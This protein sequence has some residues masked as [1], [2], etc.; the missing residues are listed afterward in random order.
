MIPKSLFSNSIKSEVVLSGYKA[1]NL[2]SLKLRFFAPHGVPSMLPHISSMLF[3]IFS[4]LFY[5][6]LILCYYSL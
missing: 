5:Y 1:T 6:A 2:G 4:M 3:H